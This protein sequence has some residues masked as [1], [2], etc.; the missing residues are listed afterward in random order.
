MLTGATLSA[1]T[2]VGIMR[3]GSSLDAVELPPFSADVHRE[4]PY[5]S[6]VGH[7]VVR[8]PAQAG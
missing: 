2:R 8:M 5:Q 7:A 1:A 3:D 4:R 6:A